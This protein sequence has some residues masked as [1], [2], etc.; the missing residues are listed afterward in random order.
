[1]PRKP[2]EEVEGGVHHVYARGSRRGL[3]FVDD[4]DRRMYLRLLG[5][6]VERHAWRCLSFCLMDNHVHLLIETPH[7]NLG[8]GMQWLHGRYG[9]H[10]NRRHD[11]SGHVFQ[12]RY[13]AAR[14]LTD[15]QLWVIVRYIARNPVEARLCA[16]VGDWPWSSHAG[17]LGDAGPRW[18]A[19]GRLLDTLRAAGG[20]PGARYAELVQA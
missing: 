9:E 15:V 20:D 16:E 19:R 3:L 17:V 7:A 5:R 13:G 4:A 12:G 11:G 10:F 8:S 14:M 2:R 18:L 1:M 6:A